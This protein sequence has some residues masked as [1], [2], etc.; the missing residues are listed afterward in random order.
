MTV[1]TSPTVAYPS[2]QI[3]TTA[4]LS[5]V[6]QQL[7]QDDSGLVVCDGGAAVAIVLTPF[8]FA[9]LRKLV[10]DLELKAA[11]LEGELDIARG[12]IVE[13][14]EMDELFAT[15]SRGNR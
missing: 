7:H 1:R 11:L 10:F 3:D 14:A 4:T 5:A 2:E 6:L 12:D 15:Y 13:H 9:E 8:A